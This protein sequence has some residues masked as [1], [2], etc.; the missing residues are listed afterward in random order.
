MSR[1]SRCTAGWTPWSRTV[2]PGKKSST[3]SRKSSVKKP[4]QPWQ[5]DL[6]VLLESFRTVFKV[7]RVKVKQG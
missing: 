2:P 3:P 6:P 5:E 1:R 7:K 4:G